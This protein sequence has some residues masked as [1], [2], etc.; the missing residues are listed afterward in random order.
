M[1][2]KWTYFVLYS[3]ALLARGTKIHLDCCFGHETRMNASNT[4]ADSTDHLV[5]LFYLLHSR[6]RCFAQVILTLWGAV[7]G[8]KL[9]SQDVGG[10]L[11]GETRIYIDAYHWIASIP[12]RIF[13][14]IS[15][16]AKIFA[17]S[18]IKAKFRPGI[19]ANHWS[20]CG[21]VIRF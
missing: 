2:R 16:P 8:S 11:R 21:H 4:A 17:G 5:Q 13:A 3:Q 1:K 7:S 15:D 12:D 10:G 19:E 6:Q 9:F 18:D 20:E 14:F